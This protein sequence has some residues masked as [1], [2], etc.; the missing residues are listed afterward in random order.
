MG[1]TPADWGL[2]KHAGERQGQLGVAVAAGDPA[3]LGLPLVMGIVIGS[4]IGFAD[5]R[6]AGA[7]GAGCVQEAG[8]VAQRWWWG[9]E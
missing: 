6:I 1:R 7:G 4:V 9:S 5:E 3:L 2:P 8:A